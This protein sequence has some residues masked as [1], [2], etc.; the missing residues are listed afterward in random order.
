MCLISVPS[1]YFSCC[2]AISMPFGVYFVTHTHTHIHATTGSKRR[3]SKVLGSIREYQ[4]GIDVEGPPT[5]GAWT[6]ERHCTACSPKLNTRQCLSRS[7]GI[8][9]LCSGRTNG[10]SADAAGGTA[11]GCRPTNSP[12]STR[13]STS[14]LETAAEAVSYTHLTLPTKA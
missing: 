4:A 2:T 3:S 10:A 7:Q 6:R 11:P 8:R 5:T 14:M 13:R 12:A 9:S 1:G